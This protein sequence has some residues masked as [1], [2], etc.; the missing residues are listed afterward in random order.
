LN[1]RRCVSVVTYCGAQPLSS[2]QIYPGNLVC[3]LFCCSASMT[4]T[5]TCQGLQSP[6]R[7]NFWPWM[8]QNIL[9]SSRLWSTICILLWEHM[10]GPCSSWRTVALEFVSSALGL[11]KTIGLSVCAPVHF[12]VFFANIHG[13]V[14]TW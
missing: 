9:S 2:V 4:H 7:P 3:N 12:D 1:T 8:I 14:I 13:L 6:H 10:V 5:S 11:G